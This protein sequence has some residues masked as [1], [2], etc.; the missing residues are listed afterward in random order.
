MSN[1]TVLRRSPRVMKPKTPDYV[2]L[3]ERII[4][5]DCIF[6]QIQEFVTHTD[7]NDLLNL[8]NSF[9]ITKKS[10]YHNDKNL[11]ED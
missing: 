5:E 6:Q 2:I 4:L 1:Q 11:R 9:Q 7:T 10:K 3:F 8:M